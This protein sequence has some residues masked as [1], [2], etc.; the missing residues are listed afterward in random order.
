MLIVIKIGTSTLTHEDGKLNMNII[1]KICKTLKKLKALGFRVI[2]VSSGAIGVGMGKIG[3]KTRPKST[4]EK[5]AL[6]A[7][8]QC[9]L[10]SIYSKEFIKYNIITA[11]VLLTADVVSNK[12]SKQ[13]VI[14]TLTALI[15]MGIIP[16]VN[17]NDTVSTNEIHGLN[18][19]D[20]DNLSAIVARLICAD[21]LIILTDIDGLYDKDPRKNNDAR[22]INIVNKTDKYIYKFAK[23]SGSNRG[24]GGMIT[25]VKA[26]RLCMEALIDCHII[27]GQNPDDIFR[28]LDGDESIGT[29]F[30]SI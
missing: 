10:M 11:Q 30:K 19:G 5:Q 16:I 20:N 3:L 6:A 17:E 15:D 14:N 25:K 18:F 4:I 8:G 23:D 26:A 1:D 12:I 27:N 21:K 7:I 2:L 22:K 24:T 29:V 9:E 13:N 28:L